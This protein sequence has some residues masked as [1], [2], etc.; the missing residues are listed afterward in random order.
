MLRITFGCKPLS[1]FVVIRV[2]KQQSN[3][4]THFLLRA[5]RFY[6]GKGKTR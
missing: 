1:I 3:Y 4:R 5:I 6:M 2:A